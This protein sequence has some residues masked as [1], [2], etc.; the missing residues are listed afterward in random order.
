M[1]I[2]ASSTEY[3]HV[4]IDGPDGVDLTAFPVKVAV[5]AHRDNPSGSEW[6]E[7]DLID[8]EARLLI[9]PGTELTLARG[10][11]RVWVSVDPP[12]AENVTRIAGHLG[13]T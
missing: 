3:L 8:G 9:G 4:P 13:V 2:P 7:A 11:Y 1:Q 10:D 6:Q 12:G 5:V